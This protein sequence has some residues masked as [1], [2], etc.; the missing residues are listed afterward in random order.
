MGNGVLAVSEIFKIKDKDGK[1][2]AYKVI[3]YLGRDEHNKKIRVS[4]T[5][6]A[7]DNLTPKKE[8]KEIQRLAD[9]FEHNARKEFEKTKG[10]K[11]SIRERKATKLS[12][13]I[14][15]QWIKKHVKDGNHTPDTVAFY[16]QMSDGIKAYF[17]KEKPNL[18]I[19]DIGKADVLDYLYYLRNTAKKKDG[20]PYGKTTIQHYFSTLRNILEYAVYLDYLAED[21]CKKI[22]QTDRPRREER[23]IDFLEEEDAV[24]FMACLDSEAEKE[25][26]KKHQGS[27]IQ[28][29][30]LINIM[31]VTGLRRGE[32]VGLQWGDINKKN[33]LLTIRRNVSID[34][35]NKGEKN[36]EKKIYVGETKGKEIR[37]VPISK[38]IVGLLDELKESRK[39][40]F[41]EEPTRDTY[42]F[43]RS[44]N[45]SLPMYP[46]EPTRMVS[47][48]IKR[49]GLPNVS[50]HDLRHTAASLAIQSGANVKEIQ[51]LMG[52]KDAATTLK[53][54]AGISEKAQRETIDGI[55]SI[56]R[57][58]TK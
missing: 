21:P 55:E 56:L 13:F 54:Y 6:A 2:R 14:D 58:V 40:E 27:H 52:H 15:E 16:T 41:G 51:A 7:P 10:Q 24:T 11:E 4:K 37:R 29:K 30:T 3:V 19:C 57:P 25:Y 48:F 32:L 17:N 26:W 39:Q 34:T 22:K 33:M 50:P 53:F 49:H 12:T 28:W 36:P 47:K 45:T 38:Y 44:D 18:K 42:I 8:E 1:A 5:I 23:E 46:T 20:K 31:I 35:S 43:C 9:E